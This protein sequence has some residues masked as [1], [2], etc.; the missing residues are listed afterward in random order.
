MRQKRD[1]SIR[2]ANLG[3]RVFL[4]P[5][6]RVEKKRENRGLCCRFD[7][8]NGQH[9]IALI[10]KCQKKGDQWLLRNRDAIENCLP[11]ATELVV[12]FETSIPDRGDNVA[13]D[14]V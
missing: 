1:T 14:R 13:L 7:G 12:L 5:N 11:G 10:D 3:P 9:G 4:E 8:Q 6:D 2:I